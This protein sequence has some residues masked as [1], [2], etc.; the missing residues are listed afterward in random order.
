MAD[1]P[2]F[3]NR[4]GDLQGVR[5]S[6]SQIECNDAGRI[7]QDT[8][9][10]AGAVFRLNYNI[11]SDPANLLRASFGF[12]GVPLEKD[13]R[14][15]HVDRTFQDAASGVQRVGRAS[16][17]S[18]RLRPGV[19]LQG[20]GLCGA[21]RELDANSEWFERRQKFGILQLLV[22]HIVERDGEILTRTKAVCLK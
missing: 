3:S 2:I 9:D 11:P 16:I 8:P 14:T 12:F 20:N 19:P 13:Q 7:V 15:F 22:I 21:G 6:A 17:A 4:S 10:A 18:G 1:I 5:R